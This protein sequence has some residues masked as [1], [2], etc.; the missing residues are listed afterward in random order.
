MRRRLMSHVAEWSMFRQFIPDVGAIL[1]CMVVARAGGV[2]RSLLGLALVAVVG[3]VSDRYYYRPAEQ[4]TA[5]LSGVPAARYELP[6]EEPRGDVLVASF[7]G[8]TL[9]MDGADSL[10]TLHIRMVISNNNGTGPWTLDTR[11]A[12]VQFEGGES[13]PPAFVNASVDGL[14]TITIPPGQ[15][16]TLDAYYL[17]P[18]ELDDPEDLPR[19]DLLWSVQTPKR[20]VVERTPFERIRIEPAAAPSVYV[21]YGFSPHWWYDPFYARPVVVRYTRPPRYYVRPRR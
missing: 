12:Q 13:R 11:S 16:R 14:P 20:L 6:P 10:D 7:G 4:A 21:S 15:A 3:C 1:L 17:L 8:S 9:E 19:F 5:S 18:P 2:K